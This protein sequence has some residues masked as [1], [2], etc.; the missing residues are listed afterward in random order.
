MKCETCAKGEATVA[1][2][3]IV[4]DT[5]K[6]F[7][8]CATCAQKKNIDTTV[9]LED[10]AKDVPVLV[11]EVKEELT[12]LA[13]AE[14]AGGIGCPACGMV[15]DEFKKAGRLGCAECYEAFASQLGRLLKRIHG[16]DRHH[17]KGMIAAIPASS[18]TV[19]SETEPVVKDSDTLE[20]L[21]DK[22]TKAVSAEAF[23]QA[24]ELRDRIRALEGRPVDGSA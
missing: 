14:D 12:S 16:A 8:L 10:K 1:Y 4:D 21:R 19:V 5:K 3:H 7:F 13:G 22:L 24:A 18:L 2:T 15:Y 6:T 17:G 23:E 20:Q 11:K 9:T